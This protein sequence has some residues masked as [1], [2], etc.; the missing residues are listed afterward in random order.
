MPSEGGST[1]AASVDITPIVEELKEINAELIS[2]NSK[3]N[4]IVLTRDSYIKD[5][6][7]KLFSNV[8]F[9]TDR[10]SYKAIAHECIE[11]A[12]ILANYFTWNNG[13]VSCAIIYGPSSIEG[14][15]NERP[16]EI[17]SKKTETASTCFAELKVKENESDA[18]Y[19]IYVKIN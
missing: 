6:A 8:S 12:T 1:P 2:L 7:G 11:K 14:K 5:I 13:S 3:E 4:N 10:R 19:Y 9:D 18:G 15:Q 16:K 17:S